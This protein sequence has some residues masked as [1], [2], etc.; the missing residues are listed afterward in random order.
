M[1]TQMITIKVKEGETFCIHKNVL[2][3]HSEYFKKALDGP[4]IEGQ[5]NLIN[6]DDIP[7]H[8][9]GLYVG[10]IY[11]LAL[12]RSELELQN[13]WPIQN[14]ENH[15]QHPWK[16]ILLLWQMGD[17]FLNVKVM[18]I[19]KAELAAKLSAY[20]V[21]EWKMRYEHTSEASCRHRM[22]RLQYAF[23]LCQDGGQPFEQSLVTAASNA[24]PQ[25]FAACVDDLENDVFKSQVTKAFALRFADPVSTAKKRK[26]DE[27]KERER[28]EKKLKIKE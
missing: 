2:V 28:Q 5:T 8:D 22:L 11:P 4:F 16:P 26:R 7:A 19:A 1:P 18:S 27:R 17:R 3:Q 10:T 13:I 15:P 14:P 25:V 21:C 6:L 12:S 23:R 20:S 24:P 9:F